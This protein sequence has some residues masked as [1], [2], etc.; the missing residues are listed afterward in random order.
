M[1]NCCGGM[2]LSYNNYQKKLKGFWKYLSTKLFVDNIATV[3]KMQ[4]WFYNEIDLL[5][6]DSA[7][8]STSNLSKNW[9]LCVITMPVEK[10][11]FLQIFSWTVDVSPFMQ[12]SSRTDILLMCRGLSKKT[13]E[14]VNPVSYNFASLKFLPCHWQHEDTI[15][16]KNLKLKISQKVRNFKRIKM[17]LS[18]H[19]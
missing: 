16:F 19:S 6:K 18:L 15:E 7:D 5:L 13:I 3:L 9:I 4:K 2:L 8:R 14:K 12:N 17:I 11:I 1:K 10:Q